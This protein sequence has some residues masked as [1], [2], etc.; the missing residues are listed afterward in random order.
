MEDKNNVMPDYVKEG[1]RLPIEFAGIR[2]Y[3]SINAMM[4]MDE[5]GLTPTGEYFIY[6]LHHHFGSIHFTI[7]LDENEQ[8]VPTDLKLPVEKEIIQMIGDAI[9]DRAM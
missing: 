9:C 2:T 6:L 3:A 8:W 1:R 7:Q 5:D 4:A